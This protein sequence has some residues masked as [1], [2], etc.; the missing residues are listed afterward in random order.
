MRV[1]LVGGT[2]IVIIIGFVVYMSSY[3][4]SFTQSAVVTTFGKVAE[5]GAVTEEGLHFKLP[6]PIQNVTLYDTRARFLQTES[7]T[8]QTA[9]D[10]QLIIES[11]LTW[12]ISD[13]QLFY[14]TFRSGASV[15]E[16]YAQAEGQLTSLLRSAMSEASNYRMSDLFAAGAGKSQLGDLEA[17]ILTR[18]RDNGPGG[19]NVEALGI[20]LMLV[21]INSIVL[22]EDTTRQVFERMT[23][24]RRRIAAQAESEGE[25]LATAIRSDA[26][27]SAARIREF[28]QL[29]A[30]QIR[31]RGDMEASQYLTTLN[32]DPE[33]ANFLAFID[34]LRGGFGERVTMVLPTSLP[35]LTL[36]SQQAAEQIQRGELPDFGISNPQVIPA[37]SDTDREAGEPQAQANTKRETP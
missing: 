19:G 35:G 11:F 37:R 22:P 28:A 2:A 29:R 10:R 33:L 6:T 15:R 27:N 1:I 7:E 8:Q 23:E 31:A 3:T 24:G 5:S 9:D 4:V 32:E 21:G 13:P 36:L 26:E 20:E 30:N 34:L 14:E 25:A 17:S 18:M 16:H 12:R